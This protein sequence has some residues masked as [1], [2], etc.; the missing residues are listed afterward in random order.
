MKRMLSLF[1][2]CLLLL[3]CAFAFAEDTGVQVIGGT[4]MEVETVNLDDWKVGETAIIP[5]FG[6]I[7]LLEVKFVDKILYYYNPEAIVPDYSYRYFESGSQADYLRIELKILNTQKKSYDFLKSFGETICTF[8]D[9]YQ[10]RGW[11]RQERYIDRCG[12]T[13]YYDAD[14]SYSIDMLYNGYYDVV[15]TLP[16]VVVSS[17]EPLSVTFTIGENEF[18]VNVRK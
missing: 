17:K 1:L 9:D 13:M 12:W 6:E 10:F 18:T 7:T 5:G 16:N 14:S 2:V 3:V 15:V 4:A 11:A 8:G